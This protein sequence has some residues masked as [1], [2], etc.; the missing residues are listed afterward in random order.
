VLLNRSP[1]DWVRSVRSHTGHRPLR[2]FERVQYWHYFPNRPN[3]TRD[4]SDEQLVHMCRRHTAEVV[5]FFRARAP[6]QL[7]VFDL[8]APQVGPMIAK[9]LDAEERPE[10]PRIDDK[11]V[12][13]SGPFKSA[14]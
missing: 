12:F 13:G 14:R 3:S 9:F 2:P 11:I 10:F 5:D 1:S 8:S 4:L 7:G 6:N